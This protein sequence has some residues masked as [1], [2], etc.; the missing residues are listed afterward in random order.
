MICFIQCIYNLY[1]SELKLQII[2]LSL[3]VP[4]K[5]LND[6]LNDQ[7]IAFH[8]GN[9]KNETEDIT[10]SR[11]LEHSLVIEFKLDVFQLNFTKVSLKTND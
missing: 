3:N 8:Y 10:H 4:T 6:F 2:I 11:V 9:E 5:E 1:A 7:E